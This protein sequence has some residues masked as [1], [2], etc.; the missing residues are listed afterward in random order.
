[1]NLT[2]SHRATVFRRRA[3]CRAGVMSV[4]PFRFP[5]LLPDASRP[6]LMGFCWLGPAAPWA[7]GV[8]GGFVLAGPSR[9]R[10]SQETL[11]EVLAPE[12]LATSHT[13]SAPTRRGTQRAGGCHQH[14]GWV[15]PM[16]DVIIARTAPATS[17]VVSRPLISGADSAS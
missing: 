4:S 2:R 9:H 15:V 8:A 1:M 11:N 5:G 6:L 3:K 17:Y 7:T 14:I 10:L 13:V 12:V 16:T